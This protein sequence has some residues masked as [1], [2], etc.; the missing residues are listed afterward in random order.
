MI[1]WTFQKLAERWFKLKFFG[2]L[3]PHSPMVITTQILLNKSV[4]IFYIPK[5]WS[6]PLWNPEEKKIAGIILCQ[7]YSKCGAR[8]QKSYLKCSHFLNVNTVRSH[9]EL[10]SCFVHKIMVFHSTTLVQRCWTADHH[11]QTPKSANLGHKRRQK[12]LIFLFLNHA[13]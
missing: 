3:P 10:V 7:Q 8:K 12:I 6:L 5:A 13:F 2:S 4:V 9:G 1:K 11:Q